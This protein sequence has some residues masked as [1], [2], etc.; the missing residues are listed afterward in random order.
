MRLSFVVLSFLLF[1]SGSAYAQGTK[2]GFIDIQRVIRDSKAGK[3][4]KASF[5]SEIQRKQQIIESKRAQLERLR[6]DF[7]KNGPVMNE[8]TRLQKAE[9]IEQLDKELNRTRADF[10]DDLQKRDVEL[11][12]KIFKDLETVLQSIGKSGGYTIILLQDALAYGD[13]SAD[14][15]Q[16]V[17]QAYDAKN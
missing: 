7:V 11:M 10:R 2:I 4:A 12:Q 16:Q 13:P 9:Q 15:T 6:N 3:A 5:E 17:I 14:I 8:T 1:V